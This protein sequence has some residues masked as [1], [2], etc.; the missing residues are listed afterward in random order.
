MPKSLVEVEYKKHPRI[1]WVIFVTCGLI[2]VILQ[3]YF[4]DPRPFVY[5]AMDSFFPIVL[6]LS[7]YFLLLFPYNKNLLL[8]GIFYVFLTAFTL[9]TRLIPKPYGTFFF[10]LAVWL[11]VDWYNYK[12]FKK[13][14]FHE[15]V[16]GNYNIALGVFLSTFIFGLITEI[17]NVPFGIWEYHIPESVSR[18]EGVPVL[19]AAFGWTPW[20]LSILAIF[21][22][23]VHQSSRKFRLFRK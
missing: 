7:L 14:I 8:I 6:A 19:M 20:T 17:V 13:G 2:F 23:F 10:L 11:L 22:P 18:S 15:F 16:S 1:F 21:Y 9:M 12:K 3:S 5:L 4:A